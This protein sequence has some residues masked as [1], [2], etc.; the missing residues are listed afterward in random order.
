MTVVGGLAGRL[1]LDDALAQLGDG[2][3]AV[4]AGGPVAGKDGLGVQPDHHLLEP[5]HLVGGRVV[6]LG[7][8][9]RAVLED[10]LDGPCLTVHQHPAAPG[11]VDDGL[12]RVGGVGGQ[13]VLP[14]AGLR[15]LAHVEDG[16]RKVL[17]EDAGPDLALGPVRH[18]LHGQLAERLVGIRHGLEQ[19]PR[20]GG[21]G[22]QPDG[23]RPEQ[24]G[25]L[26]PQAI[27]TT[28]SRSDE[29]RPSATRMPISRAIGTVSARA[30]GSA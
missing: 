8:V 17:E 16:V 21:P 23:Q 7:G 6:E 3:L 18:D 20:G 5:Q 14:A 29:S 2:E 4:P 24:P 9:P 22:D 28:T 1:D 19:D 12:L 15:H 25:G 27:I 10:H 13:N 26:I 11:Q 30:C